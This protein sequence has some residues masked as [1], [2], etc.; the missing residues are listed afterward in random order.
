[1]KLQKKAPI[2]SAF[3]PANATRGKASGVDEQNRSVD[4]AIKSFEL[5]VSAPSHQEES[6]DD[7]SGAESEDD[8]YSWYPSSA[9]FNQNFR[10]CSITSDSNAINPNVPIL[11][12]GNYVSNL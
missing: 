1:M 4:E 7:E 3:A 12:L 9:Q 6:A 5:T 2:L 11:S 10:R 8:V